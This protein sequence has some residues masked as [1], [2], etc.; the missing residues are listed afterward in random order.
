MKIEGSNLWYLVGLIATD[1]CLCPDGRHIDITSK[2]SQF[3]QAIK[4]ATG[5]KNKIGIKYNSKN[6]RCF[7]IQVGNKNLYNFL[8]SIGLTQNK[9]LTLGALEIPNQYF[10]DFLRGVIDGDGCIRRWVHPTNKGEQ[11]SL[12]IYSGSE[13]FVHWLSDTIAGLLE[14][15]GKIH[16][17]RNNFWVLKYGKMAAREIAKQCYYK[18]CFGLERKINLAQQCLS[19]YTGWDKSTTVYCEPS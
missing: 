16:N 12:R 8:L 1:G 2:D 13:E 6:Q 4:D 9:S 5:L 19:S 11:W 17:S 10:V 18:H 15:F 14:V 7:H 3:L